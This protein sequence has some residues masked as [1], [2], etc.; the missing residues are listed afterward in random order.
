MKRVTAMIAVALTCALVLPAM[1]AEPKMTIKEVM[2]L[3]KEGLHKKFQDGSATKEEAA[4]LLA[5]YEE[6]A[7][8]K[9]PKGDEA[10]WKSL[11]DA[12][13]AATA[14]EHGLTLCTGNDKHFRPVKDI[15]MKVFRP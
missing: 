10:S 9:P 8:N 11:N 1:A 3:H 15:A 6:M 2:K 12:L 14:V 5:A 13:I 4:K 7:K